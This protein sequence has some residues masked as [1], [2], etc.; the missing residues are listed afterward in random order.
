MKA[1]VTGASSGIGRDMA[2]YLS[3]LGYDLILVARR[4]DKL[5]LLKEKI[6]T[7]VQI[8]SLDLAIPDNCYKLYDMV[9]NQDTDILINNAGFG[10]FGRFTD[11]NIEEELNMIDIN[12]KAVHILTKLFLKDFVKNNKGYILNVA[13]TAGFFSGPLM[14]TY[15]ATKGYILKLTEAINQELKKQKSN[16]YV[17]L[18]C[19]GPV[20]TEFN[21]VANVRFNLKSME[22]N[23]VAIYAI[24]KML[25]KKTIIIPGIINKFL[26]VTGKILPRNL[27]TKITYKIQRRKGNIK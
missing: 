12:I 2:I 11:T 4:E 20:N 13:S 3:R 26:V 24:N 27:M 19:P 22:S 21:E 6:K 7:D 17:G 15:Y 25:K 14:S 9:K 5:L 8:V 1:L 16:V 18:L 10:L 23:D